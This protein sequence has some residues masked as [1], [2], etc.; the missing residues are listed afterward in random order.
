MASIHQQE[1]SV[2]SRR[3]IIPCGS[4]LVVSADRREPLVS[5]RRMKKKQKEEE[6][7]GYIQREEISNIKL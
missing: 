5:W 6:K 4:Y 3:R 7:E 2:H 1:K